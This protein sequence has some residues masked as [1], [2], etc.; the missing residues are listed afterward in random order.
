MKRLALL[1]LGLALTSASLQ[2]DDQTRNI[3][4]E[5]KEQGFY[6][7]EIDGAT[8]PAFSAAL[9]RYQIRNGLE[10]TGQPNAETLAAL[11]IGGRPPPA[12][13]GAA[14]RTAARQPRAREAAARGCTSTARRRSAEESGDRGRRSASAERHGAADDT[15]AIRPSCR[16]RRTLTGRHRMPLAV[17]GTPKSTRGHPLNGLPWFYRSRRCGRRSAFWRIRD[18]TGTQSMAI[19][20]Q[21]RRRRCFRISGHI[22]CR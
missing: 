17:R 15:P 6:F 19:R 18:F 4:A 20:D 14:A 16:R 3:Q 22:G 2:A 8:G 12:T 11:G 10:V 9:K 1:L 21:R 7:G 13:A 5:L